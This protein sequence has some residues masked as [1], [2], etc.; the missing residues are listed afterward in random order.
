MMKAAMVWLLAMGAVVL[1]SASVLA[2]ETKGLEKGKKYL[3]I[4]ADD[5]GMCHSENVATFDAMEKGVVSSASIM[6]PCP[7]FKEAAEY[8]RKHP[9]KDFGVHITL[10]SEWDNYRWGPVASK[11][12]VPS[13]VDKEGYLWDNV[14]LV[15][16]NA[17]AD[18]VEIE[19]RAQIERC[20][21]FGV[22]VTH[23]D[24]HMG[25]V[26]ARPEIAQVYIKLG[27]EYSIPILFIRDP[28]QIA[29]ESP[30]I[31]KAVGMAVKL[32]ESQGL[33]VLDN[34]EQYY[35]GDTLE[36]RWKNYNT[37]LDGLKP[38][39]TQLIIHCG[40]D[41]E[42]LQGITGSFKGRDGDRQIFTDPKMA[43]KLKALDIQVITWKQFREMAN[44]GRTK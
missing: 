26:L 1:G 18:E 32:L 44:A 39:V 23:L 43:E 8:A 37:C 13:L 4:H 2:A 36:E 35:G 42:E 17:K 34:L 9:E 16:K 25:S 33:P 22:P 19:I 20:K 31:A 10:T 3:I 15:A 14:A 27:L 12:K 24:T 5:A 41:N 40:Y 30:E 29:E 28:K 7:W 6:A 21:Q 38:G 11:D